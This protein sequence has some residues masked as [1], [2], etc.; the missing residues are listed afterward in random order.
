MNDKEISKLLEKAEKGDPK[1]IAK[2]VAYLIIFDK[3]LKAQLTELNK[4][5]AQEVAG[6]E[7]KELRYI[8]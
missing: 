6:K 4:A 5:L 7:D 2:L 3:R 1:A 8:A